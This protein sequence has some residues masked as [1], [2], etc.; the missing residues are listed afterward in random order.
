V[1]SVT[2]SDTSGANAADVSSG[3]GGG[4]GGGGGGGGGGQ[5][6]KAPQT[7]KSSDLDATRLVKVNYY[8][9]ILLG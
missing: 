4:T 7:W 2:E 1:L 3:G 6:E 5:E 8:T 9:R